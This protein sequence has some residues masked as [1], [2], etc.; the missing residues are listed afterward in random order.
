MKRFFIFLVSVCFLLSLNFFRAKAV[1]GFVTHAD[2]TWHTESRRYHR[3]YTS[4]EKI[5]KLLYYIRALQ[6]KG[7]ASFD[8]E[9]LAGTSCKII[10]YYQ[11][12]QRQIYYLQSDRYLS[13][14]AHPWE[15]V[16]QEQAEK[17]YP[18]LDEMNS[19][20]P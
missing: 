5:Q 13:V 19:D 12:G 18:L 16:R 2:V 8:P 10:L 14:D 15:R 11:T 4:G 1:T 17:L 7:N 6:P 3:H 20:F 9:I